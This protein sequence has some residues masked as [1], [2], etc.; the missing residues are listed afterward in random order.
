MS[1][2]LAAAHQLAVWSGEGWDADAVDAAVSRLNISAAQ[3]A[4]VGP[5][6]AVRAAAVGPDS[7]VI[8]ER[9]RGAGS[10]RRHSAVR[11][12]RALGRHRAHRVVRRVAALGSAGRSGSETVRH[13][14]RV[15][16]AGKVHGRALRTWTLYRSR[17][18][19]GRHVRR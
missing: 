12:H 11:R 18:V 1:G 16:A 15:D 17:R 9:E 5:A 13:A 10:G 8:E 4:A 19:E 2:G 6:T 14:G 3:H 7:A